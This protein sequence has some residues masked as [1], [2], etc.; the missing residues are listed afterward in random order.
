MSGSDDRAE[1]QL[2]VRGQEETIRAAEDIRGAY[3]RAAHGMSEAFHGVGGK[4]RGAV[5]GVIEDI[6]ESIK[7]VSS[8]AVRLSAVFGRMNLDEAV[9]S[10]ERYNE[11]I[12]RIATSWGAKSGEIKTKLTEVSKGILVG[13]PQI[14]SEAAALANLTGSFNDALGEMEGLGEEAIATGRTSAEMKPL[15]E[16]LH[17]VLGVAGDTREALGKI[18]AQAEE[19]GTVGGPAALEQQI[20]SMGVVLDHFS[21]QTEESRNRLTALM[22]VLGKGLAPGAANRVQ[23]QVLNTLEGSALD[24]SRTLGHDILDEEGKVKDPAQVIGDLQRSMQRR[25]LSG[26]RQLLAWRRYLGAQAGSR[27]YSGLKSGELGPETIAKLAGLAPSETG[28]EAAADFRKDDEG[29]RVANEF[30]H[31]R[32][33]REAVQPIVDVRGAWGRFFADNPITGAIASSILVAVGGSLAKGIGSGAGKLAGLISGGA[34]GGGAAMAA[35]EGAAG[36]AAAAGG[37]AAVVGEALVGTAEAAEAAEGA[38]LTATG[39]L[40]PFVIALAGAAAQLGALATI[41][42][43]RDAMGEKWRQEHDDII[44]AEKANTPYARR[45]R[46]EKQERADVGSLVEFGVTRSETN[47][48]FGAHGFEEMI[49]AYNPA[50]YER[51]KDSDVLK[52]VLKAL[53][54]GK[55]G[56]ELGKEIGDRVAQAI[57]ENPPVTVQADPDHPVKVVKAQK[58]GRGSWQDYINGRGHHGG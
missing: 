45:F 44:E 57:K 33:S 25:G 20:E 51:S 7:E 6:G 36:G 41:G 1:V 50:L 16:V 27:V 10:A 39:A 28:H 32:A 13:E 47:K 55:V 5:G 53:E 11:S 35:G 9:E 52:G 26:H 29:Q 21:A 15:G 30:Q 17:N 43:N 31:E 22:A 46:R 38:L 23:S 12:A 8:D 19:L 56:P 2:G 18:R 48:N 14:A 37:E 4:I 58:P 34:E 54:T 3:T 49:K 40:N 24:I 42:E